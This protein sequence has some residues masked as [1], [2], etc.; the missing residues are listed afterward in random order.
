LAPIV[1]IFVRVLSNHIRL[2]SMGTDADN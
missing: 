1:I 2:F